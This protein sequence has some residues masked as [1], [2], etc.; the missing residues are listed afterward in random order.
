VIA[1]GFDGGEPSPRLD[2]VIAERPMP[3]VATTSTPEAED[4]APEKAREVVPVATGVIP[5]S[6]S[7]SVFGD[8]DLDIPDFLK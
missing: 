5:D 6:S 4:E 2:P 1:A 7:D 3:V 8:D